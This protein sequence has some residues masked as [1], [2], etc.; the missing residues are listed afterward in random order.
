MT[1][2]FLWG[3]VLS[4]AWQEEVCTHR[5]LGRGEPWLTRSDPEGVP[6]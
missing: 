5:A 6:P 3:R 1:S 4:G 2:A